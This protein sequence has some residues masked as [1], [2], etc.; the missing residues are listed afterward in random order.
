MGSKT[1]GQA[2][3]GG[4]SCRV[5]R[6]FYGA[7]RESFVAPMETLD[8]ELLDSSSGPLQ[9]VF[10][11]APY[12]ETVWGEQIQVLA[13]LQQDQNRQQITAIREKNILGLSF[14]PELTDSPIWHRYF[15]NMVRTALAQ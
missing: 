11:R 10:I 6:N 12:I 3:I 4:L 15:I 2:G 7:Q 13:I 8:S 14:H 1:S 9:G 5:H